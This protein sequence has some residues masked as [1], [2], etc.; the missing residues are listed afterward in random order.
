MGSS[1]LLFSTFH[2][3]TATVVYAAFGGVL[4]AIGASFGYQV[5]GH[6][7]ERVTIWLRVFSIRIS[8]NNQSQLAQSLFS[9]LRHRQLFGT[10][11][12]RA[13]PE[14]DSRRPHRLLFSA[15]GGELG[16]PFLAR[17]QCCSASCFSFHT[18]FPN[19]HRHPGRV[20]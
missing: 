13:A 8:V 11:L 7:Q 3:A 5:F 12:D 10:G 14:L 1:L 17:W 18:R 19:R 2:I 15:V 9:R 4:F 20:R 16:L 6:V